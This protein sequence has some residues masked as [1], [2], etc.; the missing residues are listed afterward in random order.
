[1]ISGKTCDEALT[2]GCRARQIERKGGGS[3]MYGRKQHVAAPSGMYP[4]V[5]KAV[6]DIIQEH[7]GG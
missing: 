6:T 1:V 7:R 3:D 5:H 2:L 4:T